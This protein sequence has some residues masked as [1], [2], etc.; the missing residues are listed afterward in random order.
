MNTDGLGTP[1]EASVS[2]NNINNNANTKTDNQSTS[3]L[4][5]NVYSLSNINDDPDRVDEAPPM[6]QL[7]YEDPNVAAWRERVAVKMG[8]GKVKGTPGRK[9]GG[10]G[11]REESVSR[12]GESLGIAKRTRLAASGR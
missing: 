4:E 5:M 10:V 9:S 12:R 8:G 6:T 11:V 2:T 7:G 1:L 3:Q